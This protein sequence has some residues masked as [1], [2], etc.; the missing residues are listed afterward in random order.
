MTLKTINRYIGTIR[1]LFKHPTGTLVKIE[2][3]L[4]VIKEYENQDISVE[5]LINELKSRMK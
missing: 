3:V 2:E 1:G 5:T 4:E